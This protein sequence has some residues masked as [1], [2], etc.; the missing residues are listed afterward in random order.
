M[1][2][3]GLWLRHFEVELLKLLAAKLGEL[4]LEMLKLEGEVLHTS[5][6]SLS[7]NFGLLE[8]SGYGLVFCS[9]SPGLVV[10]GASNQWYSVRSES[11]LSSVL[12]R[13]IR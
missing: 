11:L 5:I 1:G 2:A 10:A 4:V 9:E 3:G 13:S 6:L 12:M 7:L 8:W